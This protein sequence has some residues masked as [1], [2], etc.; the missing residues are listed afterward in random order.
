MQNQQIMIWY[1]IYLYDINTLASSYIA[2]MAASSSTKSSFTSAS[3]E[4]QA[5]PSTAHFLVRESIAGLHSHLK[6]QS[7]NPLCYYVTPYE[8][9]TY[10]NS[11]YHTLYFSVCF[12]FTNQ[13]PRKG[14]LYSLSALLGQ[15]LSRTLCKLSHGIIITTSRPKLTQTL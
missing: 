1:I 11:E 6:D 10:I 3:F 7:A 12:T 4:R 14:L 13:Q 15:L 8:N 9:N 2:F 5:K